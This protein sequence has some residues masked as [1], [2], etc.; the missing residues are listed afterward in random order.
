MHIRKIQLLNVRGFREVDLDLSRPDGTLAGW[1]VLAGRNGSG[2]STLLKALALAVV[3]SDA[4][5]SLYPSFEDWV[6]SGA[7]E[8]RAEIA[9][10]IGASA[11]S[12]LRWAKL[13]W[14]DQKPEEPILVDPA[15]A[16]L[17]LWRVKLEFLVQEE[18][19]TI[20]AVGRFAL[21]KQIQEARQ[22]IQTLGEE[23]LLEPSFLA[24]YGPYRRLSGHGVDA[25]RLME[26]PAPIARV[27]NLFREDASLVESVTWLREIYLQRLEEKP[28]AA[29][30][31]RSVLAL[32]N[33]GLLPDGTK[34]EQ[35]DSEGLWTTQYG[36]RLPLRELSDGYR[37]VAALV[38]DIVRHL[39]RTFGE[40]LIERARDAEGP[41]W[42]IL[43]EG[44]VLIDEVDL[45][46][47]VSWQKRIGFWLKRHFPQIQF[48]VTTHSPFVC[49]A[50]DARGLIRLP[51]P[52][53][54]RVVEHVSEDLYNTVVHG[55]L[56]DAVLTEL[57]GLDTP[58]SEETERLRETV[59]QL[60]AKLQTGTATDQDRGTLQDLRSRLPRTM[61]SSV[62]QA[63]RTLAAE[64]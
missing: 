38:M 62:E 49:Q 18:A 9:T 22:R 45:H 64:G 61:S 50:A 60:E 16:A 20:D 46:L 17:S 3:G 8:A 51:A 24:A 2:K 48:I 57:F 13:R 10:E 54:N 29:N 33:D 30:L 41:F 40:L 14:R 25:Q 47:H 28:G 21:Q 44:V 36:V 56:D 27:V 23:L 5:R 35:I 34:V 37:T 4:A 53:E 11:T 39:H 59:A 15:K 43:H 42:R 63:L 32:L 19:I 55:S 12:S 6:R 26:G 31:E 52:G 7:S 1:T 58:Y